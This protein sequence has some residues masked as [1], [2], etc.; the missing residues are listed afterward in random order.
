M[1]WRLTALFAF[2][3]AVWWFTAEGR[4]A[5]LPLVDD[6]AGEPAPTWADADWDVFSAKVNRGLEEGWDTLPVGPAMA[7][8]GRTFVGTAY[9]PGTLDPPGPEGVVVNF[10]ELDCVT[11]VETVFATV[12]F[13]RLPD[14]AELLEDR[15]AAEQRY[16][17]LLAELRYRAGFVDGYPSRLHYFSEWIA[18]NDRRGLVRPLAREME[19]EADT[20]AIDFMTTH[21]DAYRQLA[22]T[23]NRSAV[24]ATEERLSARPRWYVPQE[25]IPAVAD[26]IREGD[27]IA[28]T[29]TVEGLDVAHTGLAVREG[30]TLRLLHAPLVGE[31]VEISERSL[32]ERIRAIEGQ[33][34]IMVARPLP[35]GEG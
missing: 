17:S 18:A 25:R 12:R 27:V 28:A 3:V 31:A 29:S 35:A 9:V 10:R 4:E 16:E 34:G 13:L 14:A 21:P 26:R 20:T 1:V 23:S 15:G 30:G 19:G 8:L 33:D 11:F 22:D 2:A 24:R 6:E 7:R 5:P 32:A